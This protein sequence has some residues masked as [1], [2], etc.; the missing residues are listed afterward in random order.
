[1][2]VGEES[3]ESTANYAFAHATAT[4]LWPSKAAAKAS[5]LTSRS[6]TSLTSSDDSWTR[7]VLPTTMELLH[8]SASPSSAAVG[9]ATVECVPDSSPDE[10]WNRQPSPFQTSF[11]FLRCY[12]LCGI[13]AQNTY[14]FCGRYDTMQRDMMSRL[15]VWKSSR[16]RKP[17]VLKGARQT[18]KTWLLKEFGRSA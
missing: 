6:W 7:N 5:T 11:L 2:R 4:C 8:R 3:A 14:D 1:M 18:G 13:L 16:R 10:L 17:L 12:A 9:E 15:D